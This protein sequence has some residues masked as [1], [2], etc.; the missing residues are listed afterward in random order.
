[1][2]Q[3]NPDKTSD[4]QSMRPSPFNIN[5]NTFGLMGDNDLNL[6]VLENQLPG[7]VRESHSIGTK[8]PATRTCT[9]WT[10][11]L[12]QRRTLLAFV[13]FFLVLA[14]LLESL[15]IISEKQQGLVAATSTLYYAWTYGPA[16]VI[17]ILSAL[18]TCVDF[19]A[20]MATPWLN[21]QREDKD[22]A[23]A[24]LTD[25]V[26]VF[27]VFVPYRAI[28][29]RDTLVAS[30]SLVSLL[31]SVMM[32]FAPSLVRRT[33]VET[34]SPITLL[35]EFMDDAS[36]LID[37]GSMMLYNA[38]GRKRYSMD[39]P[40]GIQGQYVFQ[41]FSPS[42]TTASSFYTTV[43]GLSFALPCE[44]AV[45]T[46]FD[47]SVPETWGSRDRFPLKLG[48]QSPSCGFISLPQSIYFEPGSLV[49]MSGV[50]RLWLAKVLSGQC[51]NQSLDA[52]N[53]RLVWVVVS[54]HLN[55]T[56]SEDY[57]AIADSKLDGLPNAKIVICKPHYSM[58]DIDIAR[59]DHDLFRASPS[60][61]T[62]TRKLGNIHAWEIVKPSIDAY[63]TADD[64]MIIPA[65]V[66]STLRD[67]DMKFDLEHAWDFDSL[68]TVI[69]GL[70]GYSYPE[71][72]SMLNY[73]SLVSSFQAYYQT[74]STFLLERAVMKET[75]A[76]APGYAIVTES[77]LFIQVLVCQ[78]LSALC[79]A[80]ALVLAAALCTGH[81]AHLSLP[82]DPRTIMGLIILAQDVAGR[83]PERLGAAKLSALTEAVSCWGS[84]RG[85]HGQD[86]SS[87]FDEQE[88]HRPAGVG[89]T[90]KT[91]TPG[92]YPSRAETKWHH[93]LSF[94]DF[95]RASLF[96]VVIGIIVTL[97]VMLSRSHRDYGIGPAHDKTYLRYTWT[98]LPALILG[99]IGTIFSAIDFELRTLAPFHAM[100]NG[101]V[102][103]R[104]SIG[105]NLSGIII[106]QALYRELHARH[107][108]AAAATVTLVFTSFLTII[109]GSIF[110]DKYMPSVSTGQLH[111]VGWFSVS[112]HEGIF[113]PIMPKAT[114]FGIQATL[115]LVNNMSYPPNTFAEFALPI[116]E[117]NSKTDIS[118]Q[119]VESNVSTLQVRAVIPALRGVLSCQR[120]SEAEIYA[121][122]LPDRTDINSAFLRVNISGKFQQESYQRTLPPPEMWVT[123]YFTLNRSQ[124]SEG[125]FASTD[126]QNC[127]GS[128]YLYLW[129][130]YLYRV[131]SK[132]SSVSVFAA[133]SCHTSI[134][135]VDVET[136]FFGADLAIMREKPPQPL[137]HTTQS[138]IPVSSAPDLLD[139]DLYKDLL[140]AHS[141]DN[142]YLDTFFR[143]LTTPQ[144]G[145]PFSTL[146]D[147]SK[148][149][150]V[151]DAIRRQHAIILA[152]ALSSTSRVNY[153]LS[154]H[155]D[156]P[157][158]EDVKDFDRLR[159]ANMKPTIYDAT[160]LDP[161]HS[162]QRV[163][164]DKTSTRL[165]QALLGSALFFSLLSWAL[166]PFRGVLP[167]PSTS[168]ASVLALLVDGNVYQS[169]TLERAELFSGT[170]LGD[171]RMFRMRVG[172]LIPDRLRDDGTSDGDR[173][174][175]GI[176]VNE[177]V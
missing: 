154:D 151:E 170:A 99:F 140:S 75:K 59:K 63:S 5:G 73:T 43:A 176:W 8:S 10:P 175:Y 141:E 166:S 110:V 44:E 70:D 134:E 144:Y 145:L 156:Q 39:Y 148:D 98:V 147:P 60:R 171:K 38:I 119:P 115:V 51:Q 121:D 79:L 41:T 15:F 7:T 130:S 113:E 17:A 35:T 52:D 69:I 55:L 11:F 48:L 100:G 96:T 18:W 71:V 58:V 68:S 146:A 133:L 76:V 164:Q 83:F 139:T 122:I 157:D 132:T 131:E 23:T 14:I 29:N 158:P 104:R 32:V 124:P 106:P 64:D 46:H 81:P 160:I 172:R 120:H 135:A 20:K 2:S 80:S 159:E 84:A 47:V 94:R 27:M 61:D 90:R 168:P 19:S 13:A 174:R 87:G 21:N 37:P 102:S 93:P 16:A 92:S 85:L 112:T 24:L 149:N 108:A 169:R 31:L 117:L 67:E 95:P 3:D 136:T 150:E 155:P 74:Y 65:S 161:S 77:R 22:I 30:T 142:G 138:V 72:E 173:N 143:I 86:S 126:C 128:D 42:P 165:V 152:Q 34:T 62:P 82:G 177:Y 97:E 56:F 105:L 28:R 167:R 78:I 9:T 57:S 118:N 114:K 123:K 12:L 116:L 153:S 107:Y 25:Y 89:K 101:L 54:F 53:Q 109:P 36:K 40:F 6:K 91:T 162:E 125:I 26:S 1:M 111:L 45:L 33:V 129:G 50:Q 127:H 88:P 4:Q 163:M 137:E 66:V 49:K 103:Y